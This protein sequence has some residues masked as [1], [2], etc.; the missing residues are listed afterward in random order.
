VAAGKAYENI[1]LVLNDLL[2]WLQKLCLSNC[3]VQNKKI[4]SAMDKL[5]FQFH[6][7]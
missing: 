7:R 5:F 3:D 2:F 1:Y 4:M 6:S